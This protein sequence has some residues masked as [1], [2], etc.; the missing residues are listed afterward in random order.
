MRFSTVTRLC[1]VKEMV[2]TVADPHMRELATKSFERE[3]S[4][5]ATLD[6]PAVPDVYDYFTEADRSYLVLEFIRGKDLEAMLAEHDG[7]FDQEQVLDWALQLCDVLGYLHNHKPQPVVFRDLK[8]SN[9]MLDPYGR[10]RLIDF[11]IAKVFQAGEKGTMIGTE[12][13]SPPE[14]YR[15]EAG[16]A[17]D[18]Y[19]LGATLHHLLSRQDPR[20][21]PP[22]SFGERP[23]HAL[24]PAVSQAF[25]AIIMRCVAYSVKDRYPDALALKEALLMIAKPQEPPPSM[26]RAAERILVEDKSAPL[27]ESTPVE[28]GTITPLW[29]FKCE[30]EIR[31]TAV[32][33]DG[34]VF[35]GAYDNNLYALTADAG[36]FLWK[37]P[38]T[39][40]IGASPSVYGDSVF[41]G[42][43]DKHLYSLRRLSGRLNW[44]FA[45]QGAI[46]S[47]PRASFD[48]VFFGS[49]DGHLYAV[50][51]T[52]GRQAWKVPVHTPVRSSPCIGDNCVYFGSEGGY[53]FCV[54]LAGKT[55]WQFQAKRGVT[56]TPVLA[57]DM[58]FVGSMDSSIYALDAHSGWAI[59]SFRTRRPIVSSPAVNQGVVYFGSSDGSLYALEVSNGRKVWSFETAG[60][61]T[62]SPA[63]HGNAVYF[64]C[65]DGSVYSLDTRKGELR[66]RFAT[67]GLVV[68]SPTIVNG[69]IYI[70]SA[71]HT[72]YALPA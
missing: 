18:V 50:N 27:P 1:A 59:W 64:G 15:G 51:V 58:V 2:N 55:K 20:M 40:G 4:I 10:V 14:Q 39:D 41:V 38:A 44:R 68:S 53:V 9:I 57:E 69:V 32:V 17:G 21:E 42:S 33:S 24:H 52:T 30:D 72:L 25:E 29:A 22:F 48:H 70:G 56:S 62:S 36:K 6:H 26:S 13:Y 43:V 3:A 60:Q 35:V 61:I 63:V 46:Y 31:S 11:G 5:L 7:F 67:G 16:P 12:G 19:A 8:P 66:W 37:Y 54:E 28:P 23:V 65:T 47:S 34:I 49:D 71:D 45:T